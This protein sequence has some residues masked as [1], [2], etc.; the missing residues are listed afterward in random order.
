MSYFPMF[1][2][3]KKKHCLVVGG[4]R[5][6][7]RKV[8]V[9]KEFGAEIKVVAPQILFEIQNIEGVICCEKYFEQEDFIDQELVVA[10]TDNSEQN[11]QISEICR[12]KNIPVNAV[13]QIEDC[14][15]IF[16]A[17]RKEGEVVAAFSS[18]GQS[19]IITQYLKNQIRVSL[20]PLLGEL[21]ACLGSLRGRL[22]QDISSERARKEIYQEL[23]QLGLEHDT[24][25]SEEEIEKIIEKYKSKEL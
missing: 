24:I 5:V 23:L 20:T 22:Q 10:A 9:L 18:G 13:D 7:L 12:K 1:I 21:A 16:P 17:Y 19:P 8:E 25:P 6:A 15:F 4:G 14:S 2:E 3:L 11:H